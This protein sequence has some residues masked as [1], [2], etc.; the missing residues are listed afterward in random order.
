MGAPVIAAAHGGLPEV[1]ADGVSGLLVRPNDADVLA[2]ALNRLLTMNKNDRV[3]M[4][5][6]G[7][8]RARRLFAKETLQEATL[9]VYAEL[10]GEHA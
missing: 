9:S 2:G 6:A 4:G 8:Q 7:M 3:T 5:L 10:I 1:I